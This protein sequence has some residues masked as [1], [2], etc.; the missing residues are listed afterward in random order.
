MDVNERAEVRGL[1]ISARISGRG[2]SRNLRA[3]ASARDMG[4]GVPMTGRT[5]T[6]TDILLGQN[7]EPMASLGHVVVGIAAARFYRK[8]QGVRW[9]FVVPAAAWS[10]V[11]LLPDADVIGFSMGVRYED[12][13]GHRGATHSIAFSIVLA[14]AIASAGRLARLPV[15]RTAATAAVVL[16]SHA[17]LDTL[18]DGGLGC[19]LF[20]PFDLTRYFAPFNPIPVAPIG[21]YF[22]SA[23]GLTVSAAELLLFAPLLWYAL[24]GDR[25]GAPSGRRWPKKGLMVMWAVPVFLLSWRGEARDNTVGYFIGEDVEFAAG[26]SEAQF[27][28]VKPGGSPDTVLAALGAPLR[29]Y[30]YYSPEDDEARQTQMATGCFAVELDREVVQ[31]AGEPEACAA[32]GVVKGVHVSDVR[33]RLPAPPEVCWHY[34]RSQTNTRFRERVICFRKGAVEFTGRFWRGRRDVP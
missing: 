18:T 8:E 2:V 12:E 5:R 31:T 33:R 6:V 7:G 24:K 30:W 14:M 1:K 9:P 23:Y 19:A 28:G 26:Y 32:L 20:W 3:T 22:F 27:V 13:W 10:L 17:I 29:E 21:L 11:S 25:L 34:T 15:L 16:V 4:R